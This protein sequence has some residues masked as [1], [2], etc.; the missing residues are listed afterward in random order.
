MTMD[1]EIVNICPICNGSG[2]SNI[3][4]SSMYNGNIN[5]YLTTTRRGKD[6]WRIRVEIK[7]DQVK[8]FLDEFGQDGELVMFIMSKENINKLQEKP[9]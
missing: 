2:E 5:S 1:N 8:Q 4:L 7:A 9:D 6:K 3:P